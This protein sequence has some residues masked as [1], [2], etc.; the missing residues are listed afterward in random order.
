MN[1]IILFGIQGSGKG[2]QARI[3][4]EKWNLKIFETGAELR[5]IT[6]ENSNLGNTVREIISRGDLVPNEIVMEII[7]HFL[8]N[9]SKE[10]R[11]LFDGLPRS[12]PQKETFD[13]LLK[14][15]G[16]Q[17]IGVFLDVPKDIVIERMKEREREDDTDEVIARRIS[18]YEN[19]TLPVIKKYEEEGKMLHIN[20]NQNIEKVHADIV[21]ALQ[22]KAL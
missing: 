1:D 17:T 12:M 9:I 7:A 3:L 8:D 4:A 20:G 6:K 18:N 14:Q 19:E 21:S 11:V 22:A 13:T 2:T 16:R 15:K 10:E 5:K